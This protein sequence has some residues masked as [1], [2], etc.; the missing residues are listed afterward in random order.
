MS[1]MYIMEPPTNGKLVLHTS[2]G[3]VDIELW[4]KEAPLA[5]RNF[6]QLC[7]ENY[8]DAT[9]F[10][11]LV[12][13]FIVQGGDPTGSGMGGESIYGEAFKDEFHSRL[14]FTHRGLVGMANGGKDDN[15]SQFFI[16]LGPT[17][18][19][20]KKHTIFGKVTGDTIYNLVKLAD[21]ETDPNERPI[22]PHY[23]KTTKILNNPYDD[24]VPRN[25]GQEI[26]NELTMKKEKKKKSKAKAH[27]KLTVLSFGDEADED[28]KSSIAVNKE[29]KQKSAHDVISDDAQMA[30][31]EFKPEVKNEDDHKWFS[32][33]IDGDVE[34][35][36]T[37]DLAAWMRHKMEER[38]AQIEQDDEDRKAADLKERKRKVMD[39]QQQSKILLKE[40]K[41]MKKKGI[42]E[43][44]EVKEVIKE[45]QEDEEKA[46]LESNENKLYA[47]YKAEQ[48]KYKKKTATNKRVKEAD[49]RTRRDREDE[50]MSMLTGFKGALFEARKPKHK[51][52]TDEE[53][54]EEPTKKKPGMDI[55]GSDWLTHTLKREEDMRDKK[56][57][58]QDL[59]AKDMNRDVD[60]MRF[61]ISDPRNP[62]NM[63]KRGAEEN[64]SSGGKGGKRK[65]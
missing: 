22:N 2:A 58:I 32:K 36:D 5:C 55:L 38:N 30:K 12:P 57:N 24:I 60:A 33:R 4:P 1:Q 43:S 37:D 49:K 27:K 45:E 10:H 52:G 44:K 16:T 48:K 62:L 31:E 18:D 3:D 39:Y 23:I 17:N 50:T 34:L 28:E 51:R 54:K 19:L 63:R 53:L 9:I 47:A 59:E 25:A 7:M 29:I 14:R 46:E 65:R 41:N 64:K 26:K 20:N 13:G 56:L 6:V 21:T 42:G 35:D 15:A 61:D 11:R 40:L 8:Y